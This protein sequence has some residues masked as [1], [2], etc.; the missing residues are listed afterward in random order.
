MPP[1][2]GHFSFGRWL[3]LCLSFIA[4]VRMVCRIST[5]DMAFSP[6]RGFQE[7]LGT[8]LPTE[9]RVFGLPGGETQSNSFRVLR[10]RHDV[11]A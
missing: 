2:E 4:H 3:G 1:Q 8:A 6:G 9:L 11:T 5:R 10:F 7:K